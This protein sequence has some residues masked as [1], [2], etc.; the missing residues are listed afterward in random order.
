M[1]GSAPV[2][3]L[4]QLQ[5]IMLSPTKR[6]A[7]QNPIPES[8]E[9]RRKRRRYGSPSPPGLSGRSLRKEGGLVPDPM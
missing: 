8:P 7:M 9:K 3:C 2:C 5:G 1:R 4:E 6:K